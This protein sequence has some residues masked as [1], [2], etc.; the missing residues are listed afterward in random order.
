MSARHFLADVLLPGTMGIS[1]VAWGVAMF[2]GVFEELAIQQFAPWVFHIG[3]RLVRRSCALPAP[4]WPPANANAIKLQSGVAKVVSPTEC[5]FREPYAE[6]PSR[7]YSRRRRDRLRGAIR[8]QGTQAL[9]E[10]R[11][12]PTIVL[13]WGGCVVIATAACGQLVLVGTYLGG[14]VVLLAGW[15]LAALGY[16]SSL[17]R[18][19]AW[20]EEIIA[21]LDA[22]LPGNRESP[23]SAGELG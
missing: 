19:R 2:A 11:M 22:A 9:V 23:V 7:F 3:P 21:E 17:D 13:L 16:K 6:L 12:S 18:G 10:C 5:L 20:T 15:G 14:V 4:V 8:W 1:I